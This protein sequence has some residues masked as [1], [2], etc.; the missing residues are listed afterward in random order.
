MRIEKTD[1]GKRI[2][3]KNGDSEWPYEI[4]NVR[5][6][7]S[8]HARIHPC[9]DELE[10]REKKIERRLIILLFQLERCLES[11]YKEPCGVVIERWEKRNRLSFDE[12]FHDQARELIEAIDGISE[13]YCINATNDGYGWSY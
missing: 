7:N 8:W 11:I 13:E 1:W 2:F 9:M 5:P 12:W 6:L 4:R 10:A 3:V